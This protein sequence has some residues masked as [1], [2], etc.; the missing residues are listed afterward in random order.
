[1]TSQLRTLFHKY[2]DVFVVAIAFTLACVSLSTAQQ[3]GE[4]IPKALEQARSLID[5]GKPNEA[6]EKL[7]SL[8]TSADP[9]VTHLLGVAFYH[10][11]DPIRAIESLTPLTEKLPADSLEKREVIQVLGLSHYLAGHLPEAIPYL[12]QTRVWAPNH[13]ELS[14]VLGMAYTQTLQPD[15]ARDT[16][17]RMFRVPADSAAAHLITSQMMMRAGIE[18]FA[19]A[20]L[21]KALEKDPK[22]PQANF[23]LGQIAIFRARFDEGIVHMERELELNPGNSM[24]LYRMGDAYTRQLKWDE[25]I[26]ALQ[27]SVWLNPFF[28][29]PYILLGK[30]YLNKGLAVKAEGM[31]RRA[32]QYDPNNKSAHYLLGQVLQQ[33]GRLED[34]KGQFE[35]AER[36]RDE[37]D[38]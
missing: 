26:E 36:L 33:L 37:P 2:H 9:R 3:V 10:A 19:E 11:N 1:M 29:G 8:T 24:A 14:F 13:M 17:A 32:V 23:L 30:A 20:E 4:E 6:I 35:I 22:L 18:K 5:S 15:K 38:R 27:K 21:K 12:E 7:K 16:F 28:S 34:A 25:A 31:L